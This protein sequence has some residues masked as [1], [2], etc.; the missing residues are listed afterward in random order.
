MRSTRRVAGLQRS[1]P[2]AAGEVLALT[3]RP[4]AI[5]LSETGPGRVVLPAINGIWGDSVAEQEPALAVRMAARVGGRDLPLDPEEVARAFPAA[6]GQLVVFLHGLGESDESWQRT[7]GG[8][9]PYGPRLAGNGLTPVYLRFNSGLRISDNGKSCARLLQELTEAW[10]VPVDR[11]VLIG[12]SMGGL[13][14]R[15]ACHY[16]VRHGEPW[17]QQVDAVVTLGS[18]HLGAPLEKAVAVTDWLLTRFP[19][20][21]PVARLLRLRS[22]GVKDLGHGRVVEEDWRG[23]DPDAFLRDTCTDVPFLPHATY[24][25]VAASI[26]R[27]V[28]HPA[29][30]LFGDGLVRYPSAAGVGRTRR[31]GFEIDNGAHLGGVGHLAL[32]NHAK[33]YEQLERWLVRRSITAA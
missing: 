33:V 11:V 3:S 17:V 30:R 12:H 22:V 19:E 16:A 9:Q 25:F 31:L 2:A 27:D 24:Y 7:R 6:T 5:P 23:H 28:R 29:G 18:P 13:I 10:P 21:V 8:N 4:D 32:L 14:A 15:S 1:G 26:T 20:T